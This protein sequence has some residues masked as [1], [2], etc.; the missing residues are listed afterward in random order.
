MCNRV[1]VSGC[2]REEL[3]RAWDYR[4][5]EIRNI[6]GEDRSKCWRDYLFKRYLGIFRKLLIYCYGVFV[7][8]II[9]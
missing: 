3:L 9:F 5:Y 4:D 2:G 6:K 8:N 1:Y 7:I